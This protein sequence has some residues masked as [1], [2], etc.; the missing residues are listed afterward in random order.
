VEEA[1]F[2]AHRDLESRHWWLRGRPRWALDVELL[3]RLQQACEHSGFGT[4]VEVALTEWHDVGESKVSLRA[5]ARAFAFLVRL[6]LRHS[7]RPTAMPPRVREQEVADRV[8]SGDD[9]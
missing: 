4:V 8:A 7:P 2:S 3:Q 1:L 5:G 9:R 6:G